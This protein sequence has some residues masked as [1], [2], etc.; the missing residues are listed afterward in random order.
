MYSYYNFHKGTK[1]IYYKRF[2]NKAIEGTIMRCRLPWYYFIRYEYLILNDNGEVNWI[3]E[4]RVAF[5]KS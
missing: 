4:G 2:R 5:I 1:V 3:P